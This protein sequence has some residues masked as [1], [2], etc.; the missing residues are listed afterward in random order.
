VTI[1]WKKE[2]VLLAIIALMFVAAAW[3]W[4][5]APVRIPAHWGADGQVNG[6]GGKFTGLMLLPL[7]TLAVWA[8]LL[9]LPRIDPRRE[10]YERFWSAFFVVRLALVIYLAAI[11][12]AI[13]FAMHGHPGAV[14]RSIPVLAGTLFI[15]VGLVLGKFRPNWF[16]GVRTPW[17]LSSDLS[18]NKT[19]RLAGWLF[20]ATGLATIAA[21]LAASSLAIDVLVGGLTLSGAV[22][23]AYSYFVWKGDPNRK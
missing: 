13:L 9:F 8:L 10:N 3:Q 19:N 4:P 16:A 1:S 2:A 12:G 14:G 11:H 20:V 6:W 5:V 15:T 7:I 21:G 17:T 23:V 22:S 18:W